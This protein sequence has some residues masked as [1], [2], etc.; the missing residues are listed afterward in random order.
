LG[1]DDVPEQVGTRAKHCILDALGAGLAGADHP[2][3]ARL[4]R[5][6]GRLEESGR[7][8][9]L[10]SPRLR[11]ML[12]AAVLNGAMMQVHDVD[13]AHLPSH[14]HPSVAVLP[15]A[16]AMAEACH[17]SGSDLLVSFVAGYELEARLGQALAP[18][19]YDRGWHA[20]STLGTFGAAAAAGRLLRLDPER[21]AT[22]LNLAGTQAGGVR[23]VFGG[24]AKHV[25]CGKAA[26]NGLLAALW[27]EAGLTAGADT[28]AHPSG[29][30]V[31]STG[32]ATPIAWD[33]AEPPRALLRATFKRFPCCLESHPSIEACLRLR[34]A[35]L[36]HARIAEVTVR[37]HPDVV[38]F[39]GDP[40]PPTGT[41][42]KFSLPHCVALA[43]VHGD[44]AMAHF[45]GEPEPVGPVAE[46]RRR[47][48]LL[49][50]DGLA[51]TEAAVEARDGAGRLW[52]AHTRHARGSPDDPFT[53]EEIEAKFLGLASPVLGPERA[54][55][56]RE[57]VLTMEALPDAAE[58]TAA[59]RL[60]GRE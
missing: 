50:D 11:P 44:V 35:G 23:A 60:A 49:A 12:H 59:C 34:A 13:E 14:T 24:M 9:V 45:S 7:A 15:A 32:A 55:R 26:L 20:T 57:L 28:L 47:V 40:D 53:A 46:V 30:A 10:A 19:H 8:T 21:M 36:S 56:L 58:L 33:P 4:G 17:A 31:A 39:V 16:L 37:V 43:L 25:Q 6:L 54:A 18:G 42:A 38:R 48:H 22:A 52:Q 1:P 51:Y 29:F 3:V 27:A 41:A 5:A 2:I